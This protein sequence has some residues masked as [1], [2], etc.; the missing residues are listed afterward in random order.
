MLHQV[1]QDHSATQLVEVDGHIL[2]NLGDSALARP[3]GIGGRLVKLV[4]AVGRIVSPSPDIEI[5]IALVGIGMKGHT[6][7]RGIC[8]E[9]ILIC[10]QLGC[11]L[12]QP[13]QALLVEPGQE[14]GTLLDGRLALLAIEGDVDRIRAEGLENGTASPMTTGRPLDIN[15]L[16]GN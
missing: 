12:P 15:D 1:I 4:L 10:I 6:M 3:L 13:W 14:Q 8:D 2:A 5:P 16:F 7:T 11:F 9:T